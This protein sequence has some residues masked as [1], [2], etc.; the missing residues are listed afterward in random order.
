MFYDLLG[1]DTDPDPT[2]RFG[3]ERIRILNTGY[4]Y[5]VLQIL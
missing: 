1:S 3:S 5:P 4:R 2:K